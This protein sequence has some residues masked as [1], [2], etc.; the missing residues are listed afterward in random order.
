L[1]VR[2]NINTEMVIH[3]I[4]CG[5]GG[6]LQAQE[7]FPK[8]S[9][10]HKPTYAYLPLFMSSWNMQEH[11]DSDLFWFGDGRIRGDF[12]PLWRFV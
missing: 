4:L 10:T 3:W 9:F 1:H 8:A 7:L 12:P 11:W 2:P 5:M 6:I